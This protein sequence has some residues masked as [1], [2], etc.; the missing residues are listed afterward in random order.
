MDLYSDAPS[1]Q[2]RNLSL[3]AVP[4]PVSVLSVPGSAR[5]TVLPVA[6]IGEFAVMLAVPM[7]LVLR[8]RVT[9][10]PVELSI[11]AVTSPDAAAAGVPDIFR[12]PVVSTVSVESFRAVDVPAPSST[13]CSV[14]DA[15]EL[16]NFNNSEYVSLILLPLSDAIVLLLKQR[17][18]YAK[19]RC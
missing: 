12:S 5:P 2:I 8:L 16:A 11:R 14:A 9:T 7:G 4:E 19:K 10:T 15:D 3:L 17:Y 13:I 18:L 6:T 1:S